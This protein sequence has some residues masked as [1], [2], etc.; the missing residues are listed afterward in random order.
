[1]DIYGEVLR[2]CAFIR[3]SDLRM[4]WKFA[5]E[6]NCNWKLVIENLYDV[7]HLS[8]VHRNSFARDF[9]PH[10]FRLQTMSGG[11]FFGE[12]RSQS[13]AGPDGKTLFRS[14]EWLPGDDKMAFGAQ[15]LPTLT[16]IGRHDAIYALVAE[17]LG[18]EKCRLT[19]YMLMPRAWFSE[20]DFKPKVDR[21]EEFMKL[22]LAED[23]DLLAS[24][25]MGLASEA[26]VPGPASDLESP[27]LHLTK[28]I[29]MRLSDLAPQAVP[30]RRD[31][32]RLGRI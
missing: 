32:E 9:D 1:M 21:Y 27:V 11:M 5:L 22:I 8:V 17:P 6:I 30:I 24:L 20:P 19:T 7:Y 10:K 15:V 28:N 14:I 12:Y 29:L 25:Q 3:A 23:L 18:C 31:P 13:V 2:R 16:L 4:A 26:Y